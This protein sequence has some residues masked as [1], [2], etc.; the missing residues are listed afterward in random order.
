MKNISII[1]KQILAQDLN[2]EVISFLK[3]NP[4]PTDADL[5]K[6]AEDNK[7][8][9][10]AVETEIYTLATKFVSIFFNGRADKTGFVEED[11]DV[12]ELKKGITVEMEHT[13]DEDVS[14]IIALDHLA[15]LPDYYTKLETI[16]PH[17]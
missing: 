5:H 14:R 17:E 15:E 12:E 13:P 1:A 10:H 9:V 7:Y 8:D 11:A 6:W 3:D 4:N 16:D 2:K